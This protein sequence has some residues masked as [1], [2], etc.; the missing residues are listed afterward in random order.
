MALIF[1]WDEEKSKRNIENHGVLFE[2]AK[3]V[4]NDPFSITI[5][6]YAHSGNEERFLDIGLSSQGRVLVVWYTEREEK[7][8]IIGC[9]IATHSERQEYEKRKF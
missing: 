9:R 5:E 8:R 1:E 4:F 6:D 7:I 2:E 3:S